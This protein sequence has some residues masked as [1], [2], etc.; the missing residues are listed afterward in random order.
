MLA[1]ETK[2]TMDS[3]REL[4]LQFII[5]A[6]GGHTP[7]FTQCLNAGV[8]IETSGNRKGIGRVSDTAGVGGSLG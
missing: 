1:I 4:E 8:D 7:E 2:L 6:S 5:A 3:K